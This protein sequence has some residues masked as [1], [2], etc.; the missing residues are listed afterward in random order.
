MDET[1]PSRE[2][3]RKNTVE[4]G[5]KVTYYDGHGSLDEL[6]EEKL[7]RESTFPIKPDDL[8]ALTKRILNDCILAPE[9]H[10]K[11]RSILSSDF[12]YWGSIIGPMDKNSFLD[13]LK[14]LKLNEAFPDYQIRAGGFRVDPID[15]N[16]V[17]FQTRW[18]GTHTKMLMNKIK[19][20]HKHLELPPAISSLTF[21]EEGLLKK[22]TSFVADR[23]C[24]NTYGYSG[25]FGVF[26]GLGEDI[27]FPSVL[28]NYLRKDNHKRRK[29]GLYFK[30]RAWFWQRRVTRQTNRRS[31][32]KK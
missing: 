21:N 20:T 17:W 31:E 6:D 12:E 32:N 18:Q 27:P 11:C 10:L 22:Y 19:P 29:P 7:L 15:L 8:V 28:E 30:F 26:R 2:T 25:V 4:Q 3:E 24:G 1:Q 9:P 13:Y 23:S 14:V 5:N 16:R